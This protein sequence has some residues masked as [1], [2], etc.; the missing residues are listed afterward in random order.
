[1]SYVNNKRIRLIS[2]N[3]KSSDV[4]IY[5]MSRD[6]RSIDN[7]AL[8]HAQELAI[9][10]G[11][12]MC[13]IFCLIPNFLNAT[14]PQYNFMLQGLKEVKDELE[15]KNISFFLL[16]GEASS[17]IPMFLENFNTPCLICDFSPLKEH[18]NWL[19]GINN[20]LKKKCL[21]KQVDSHNIIPVWYCSDKKEYSAR[22]LR[23]KIQ[24]NIKEFLTPF[25]LLKKNINPFVFSKTQFNKNIIF[26]DFKN[27]I[28]KNIYSFKPGQKEALKVLKDFLNKKLNK[29]DLRNDPLEDVLTNLSPYLHFGNI[30]SQR[31]ILESNKVSNKNLNLLFEEIVVRKELSDNFCYYENNYN[32]FNGL[33]EWSKKTLIKHEKDKR[34]FLY[35][36]LEFETAKTHDPLWNASQIQ[37]VKTGKMHGYLR[38][39]WAKKILE[40]TP[41]PKKAIEISIYLNDKYSLDGRDPNGYVGCLWSIGGLHDRPFI[42][43]NIFGQVRYM[44]YESCFK[45]FNVNEFINK[46]EKL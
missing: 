44:K 39:Y 14:E 20:N 28:K 7:W 27:L 9:K 40:W 36:Q 37:M 4:I 24:K 43:R 15:K 6:Q 12:P 3:V 22:T 35:N 46:I 10:Q 34:D 30:C 18:K 16:S 21:I 8:L 19:N 1:M 17:V 25:P 23:P 11:I 32:N 41:N 26:L 42:E 13:V 33:P 38:M 2:N 29:F 5:W 31:V 45:K